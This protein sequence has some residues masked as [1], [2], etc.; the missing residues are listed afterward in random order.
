MLPVIFIL[1]LLL[2][3]AQIES[4][5]IYRA[6][7]GEI[8]I[9]SWFYYNATLMPGGQR[10]INYTIT[11]MDS[12]QVSYSV[13]TIYT[14]GYVSKTSKN[15]DLTETPK[16]DFW[17]DISSY[18]DF[19]ER[20]NGTTPTVEITCRTRIFSINDT[21]IHFAINTSSV[22]RDRIDEEIIKV[23]T[24][25]I[26]VYQW[27][28]MTTITENLVSSNIYIYN[29]ISWEYK[30]IQEETGE[31]EGGVAFDIRILISISIVAAIL[32]GTVI[33]LKKR[34]HS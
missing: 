30:N 12:H 16:C 5:P 1:I 9:D 24:Y 23:N 14:S 11:G 25:G 21:F 31:E 17:I 32:L 8:G 7:N 13:C 2:Q 33:Y 34:K 26:I 20:I 18:A 29:L 6:S 27:I 4:N 28:N 15:V 3:P 22:I 10:Y 19:L